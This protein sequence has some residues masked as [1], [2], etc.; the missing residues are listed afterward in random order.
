[1]ES[2][3]PLVLDISSD[4]ETGFV[5]AA[6]E[7]GGVEIG[8]KEDGDWLSK[9]LVEV[10]GNIDD[11]SD[12]V[13]FLSEVLPQKKQ[14]SESVKPKVVDDD[15]DD[16]VVLDGDPDGSAVVVSSN[17]ADDSDDLEI[18]GEKGEVW[19][20]FLLAIMLFF[21]FFRFVYRSSDHYLLVDVSE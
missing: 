20:P 11:G 21:Q 9:L 18:V 13:V 10:G 16:C 19:V 1:M 8:D 2:Q 14:R 12:D 6:G 17:K 3:G 15:D 4:E 5:D 7:G